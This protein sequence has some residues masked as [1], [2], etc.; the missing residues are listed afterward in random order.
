M[1]TLTKYKSYYESHVKVDPITGCELWTGCKNNIGYGMFRY[2][3]KMRTVHRLK[4]EWE[5][6]DIDKKIVYHTCNNYHCVNPDHLRVGTLFDKAQMMLSRGNYSEIL[7]NPIHYKTCEYCG[8]H[9][10]RTVYHQ[11]HASK[12][13]HKP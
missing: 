8:Y 6:H 1:T 5:G 7:T 9:G 3:G 13:K 12:C 4:M 10:P 11:Y 2:D